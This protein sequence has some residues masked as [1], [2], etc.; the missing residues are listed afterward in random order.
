MRTQR[1]A[2]ARRL[3]PGAAGGNVSTRL[4][5]CTTQ[6]SYNPRATMRTSRVRLIA[7]I[8]AMAMSACGASQAVAPTRFATPQPTPSP[9]S[10]QAATP[11]P[12]HVTVV[13]AAYVAADL[14]GLEQGI[15]LPDTPAQEYLSLG[16]RQPSAYHLLP[17]HP[18]WIPAVPRTVP[19]PVPPPG[20]PNLTPPHHTHTPNHPPPPP[21]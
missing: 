5:D 19:P 8:L 2:G 4:V 10:S 11:A 6:R 20:Q 15:R 16:R 21:P 1:G 17:A 12:P 7:P 18:D 13:D 14:S 9:V 3:H